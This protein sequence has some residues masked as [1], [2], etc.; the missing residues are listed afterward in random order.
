[1]PDVPVK[2][3]VRT[4]SNVPKMTLISFLKSTQCTRCFADPED[5]RQRVGSMSHRKL[6]IKRIGKAAEQAAEEDVDHVENVVDD[7]ENVESGFRVPI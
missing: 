3:E 7:V 5:A 2:H 6:L 4:E 1:M